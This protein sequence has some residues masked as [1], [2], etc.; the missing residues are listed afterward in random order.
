MAT[1]NLVYSPFPRV[2]VDVGLEGRLGRRWLESGAEGD[3]ARLHFHVRYNFY[4][5]YNF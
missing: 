3:L 2:D 5:F 1:D 4:N